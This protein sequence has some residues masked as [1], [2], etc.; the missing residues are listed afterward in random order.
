V[1]A[2]L[3]GAVLPGPDPEHPFEIGRRKI[4]G[5]VSNGMLASPRELRVG[6]EGGG[7]WVLDAGAPLGADLAGWLALDDA[8]LELEVTP[9]RGYGLSV[10][11]VAR[12]VAAL[13]GAGLRLPDVPAPPAAGTGVPVT[14]AEPGACARFD[15]R[16]ISGVR[17]AAASPAW[18]Q[19]RLAA[20]GMRPISA[21]VD[22]TNLA[23]LETGHPAHAYDLDRLAGPRIEVRRAG[24]GERLTTLDGV[25][26][27][28]DP[29]DLVIADAGGPVGFAGVMGG[30]RTEVGPRTRT[31]LLEVAAFDPRSVLRTARRHQ[32]LSEASKRFEKTV[33]AGTVPFGAGRC[34][35]LIAEFAGGEITGHDD[36]GGPPPAREA[37][38]LRPARARR[39]P[40]GIA[41]DAHRLRRA[42]RTRRAAGRAAGLAA[43]PRCRGRP[44][45][46]DRSPA[47]VRRGGIDRA[48]ERPGGRAGARGRRGA[49]GAPRAGR[50]RVE[51]GADAAVR[52]RWGRGP[53]RS[54]G[55]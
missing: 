41:V 31:V 49:R 35:A 33:P 4:F 44:V 16:R 36:H 1:A 10:V 19:V 9:D 18:A 30:E 48:L 3:P 32:L 23:M 22:A 24:R 29:D 5:H 7:I 50:G 43:G 26:R 17:P 20:A 34:A 47:R 13:T 42:G 38:T 55:R 54:R 6:D 37:I 52:P 14:V 27:E 2:A 28:C 25:T 40:A 46:G 21:V 45:R 15:A 11:G 39:R 51:R 53:A 8:V 12:D